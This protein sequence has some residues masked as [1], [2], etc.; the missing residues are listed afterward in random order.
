MYLDIQKGLI[1]EDLPSDE[2]KGRWKSFVHKWYI[3]I[4][5]LLSLPVC[6][7]CEEGRTDTPRNRGDLAEGWYD[8]ATLAKARRGVDEPTGRSTSWRE[9]RDVSDDNEDDDDEYGPTLP[10]LARPGDRSGPT[11][12]SMQD[13]EM[14]NGE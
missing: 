11:I 14:R 13:L 2:M 3:L 12:P 7:L 8:P 10:G 9:S 5:Y 4:P 1:L 6:V